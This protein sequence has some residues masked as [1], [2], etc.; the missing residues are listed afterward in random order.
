MTLRPATLDDIPEMKELYRQTILEVNSRDYTPEQV[1]AWAST[2][3]RTDTLASRIQSQYFLVA[4]SPQ[5]NI[6]GFASIE[7]PDYLDMVYVH[8][9][10][11]RQG[12][13]RL[14]MEEMIR[15]ARENGFAQIES[16]V[17]VTARPLFEAFGFVWVADQWPEV[18]GVSMPNFKLRL[19]L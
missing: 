9:D 19:P 12:V 8:K 1:E 15:Y 7:A 16:D 10:F 11:Q 3:D 6:A 13:G 18:K 5:G 14:L 2:A 4:V 17:S